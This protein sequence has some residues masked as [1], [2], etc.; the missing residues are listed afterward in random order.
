MDDAEYVIFA[1][2]SCTRICLDAIK[3]L[4][5]E[6]HKVGMF[7]PITLYP[8]PEKQIQAMH[9]Y[10]AALSV[11]MALPEQF[12]PDVAVNLDRSIPL[13]SYTRCGGNLVEAGD[14]AAAMRR[15][16]SAQEGR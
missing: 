16:I 7:R 12:Y 5:A 1:W 4:R 11:E 8:F 14:V 2:G 9:G 13:S 15:I 10:K 3:E 6:G